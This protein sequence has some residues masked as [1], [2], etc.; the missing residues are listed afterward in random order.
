MALTYEESAALMADI[1][2]RDRIKVACLRYTDFIM[3]EA[4]SVPAHNTRVKWAQNTMQAPDSAAMQVQP[5]VVMD[6]QVQTDGSTITDAA[7]Q[8]AVETSINKML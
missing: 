4:A 5:T 3:A 6:P 7:L 1:A 2:F 8:T